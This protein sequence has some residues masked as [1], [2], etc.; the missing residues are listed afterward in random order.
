M[1]HKTPAV[2]RMVG[3]RFAKHRLAASRRANKNDVVAEIMLWQRPFYSGDFRGH[4]HKSRLFDKLIANPPGDIDVLL[5][6]GTN[7]G[8]SNFGNGFNSYL[9]LIWRITSS[10]SCVSVWFS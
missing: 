9:P 6:E 5:I 7:I 3:R 2:E 10:N 8:R 4:G 1:T